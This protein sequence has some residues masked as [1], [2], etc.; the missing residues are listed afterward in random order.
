MSD[1]APVDGM[2]GRHFVSKAG[3]V[4]RIRKLADDA[5]RITWRMK[6]SDEDIGEF[7]V[8]IMGI[9]GPLNITTCRGRERE[10][11]ELE[12]WLKR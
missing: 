6:P 12:K 3:N 7:E 5:L 2:K 9:L 4:C 8:W 11:E 1:Q 10:A